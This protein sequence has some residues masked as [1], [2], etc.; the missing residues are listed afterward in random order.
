[1]DSAPPNRVQRTQGSARPHPSEG[2]AMRRTTGL[3]I[4]LALLAGCGKEKELPTFIPTPDQNVVPAV[5][6]PEKSHPDAAKVVERCL[7]ISTDGHPE[8]VEKLKAN[9]AMMKGSVVRPGAG[10]VIIP[11]VRRFESV[12]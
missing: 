12:W 6:I 10:T 8:R 4:G 11:T 7:K 9:R 5:Q 2:G 1:M 3:V